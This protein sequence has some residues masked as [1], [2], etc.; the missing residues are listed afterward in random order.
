MLKPQ[1]DWLAAAQA[2]VD[3]L[4]ALPDAQGR[5]AL[6]ETVCAGLGDALYPAFVNLLCHIE[7]QGEPAVQ[8]LVA[9]ALVQALRSGRLPSGRLAAWGTALQG[10]GDAGAA[11]G[12]GRSLGPVEYLCAWHAQPSG[13][14][15]LPANAFDAA[16]QPL[17]RLV[18]AS[19]DA[20]A[21]YCAK[22]RA[23]AQDP[24][25]GSWSRSA[26]QGVLA[27]ADAWE[28][29]APADDVAASCLA[30]LNGGSSLGR[31]RAGLL[32]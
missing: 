8:A 4:D 12:H 16:L 6:M 30:A 31:L 32:G 13:R 5:T 24:L 26:R 10:G 3:G 20:R 21:L 23:D 29:G 17:L 9:D 18:G 11:F 25:G 19:A 22:L 28:A 2:L 27:L 7:R 1:P 14:E 15:P